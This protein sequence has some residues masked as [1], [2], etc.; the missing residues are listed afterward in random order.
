MA[1]ELLGTYDPLEV[2]TII[3]GLEMSGFMDGTFVEC[4]RTDPEMFKKKVGAWGEVSR[5]KNNNISGTIKF[6]LL[7][8]SPS[9]LILDGLKLLTTAFPA[10]VKNDGGGKRM[11]VASSAWIDN[12]PKYTYG[13][14]DEGVEWIIGCADLIQSH[15]P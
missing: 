6:T 10:M 9:N 4:E 2:K 13:M 15:L 8:T 7:A 12:E 11:S 3:A 1:G 5:S 14:E